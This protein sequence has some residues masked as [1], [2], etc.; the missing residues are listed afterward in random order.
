MR[1]RFQHKYLGFAG[2]LIGLV[3]IVMYIMGRNLICDCGFIKFWHADT[4]TQNSQHLFDYYTFS[5]IIHGFLFY[6][7]I[8]RF[9]KKLPPGMQFVVAILIEA[10]WELAENSP[11][12]VNRYQTAT[13]ADAY[14]GDSIINSVSDVLSMSLGYWFAARNKTWLTLALLVFMEV[15]VLL[16]IRDN[17]TLNIIMLIFPIEAIK[18]WQMGGT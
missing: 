7:L 11:S 2:I 1:A 15:G 14:H 5:H 4:T 13:A 16:L 18:N 10:A 17:L 6:W 12:I 8:R 3:A 9:A